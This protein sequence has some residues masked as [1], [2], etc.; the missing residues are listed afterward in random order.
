M[1]PHIYLA[2]SWYDCGH[3]YESWVCSDGIRIYA[4]KGNTPRAA[5]MDWLVM[6]GEA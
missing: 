3:R 2:Y 4:G 1:K 6:Q 5:Y